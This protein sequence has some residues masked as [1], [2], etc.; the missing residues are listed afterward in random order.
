MTGRVLR[1]LER[2]GTVGRVGR[3]GLTLLNPARLEAG[4]TENRQN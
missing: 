1:E 3:A 2:E 4:A